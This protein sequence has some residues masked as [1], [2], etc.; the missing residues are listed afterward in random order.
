M[1]VYLMQIYTKYKARLLLLI[2]LPPSP[3][4][5]PWGR[6]WYQFDVH[7]SN[8]SP[9]IMYIST[10]LCIS[11]HSYTC[12]C[13]YIQLHLNL[14]LYIYLVLVYSFRDYLPLH[15]CDFFSFNRNSIIL[16]TLLQLNF[17]LNNTYWRY[18]QINTSKSTSFV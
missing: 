7:P 3:H 1:C 12:T 2:L 10:C 6:P 14:H 18:S 11:S 8:Y 5:H 4:S 15:L 16:Y 17:S 13:V 9:Y